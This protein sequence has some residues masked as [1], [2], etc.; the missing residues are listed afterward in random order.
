MLVCV[1]DCEHVHTYD[2]VLGAHEGGAGAWE[3][4]ACGEDRGACVH[5]ERV[6]TPR[7]CGPAAW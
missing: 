2:L 1:R 7:V 4:H 6:C 5:D 3:D